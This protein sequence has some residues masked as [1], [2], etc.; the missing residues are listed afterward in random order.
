MIIPIHLPKEQKEQII[1]KVQAY[2]EEER[3]ETIGDLAAEQ[4]IDFM[5]KE[6]GPYLYNKA[7]ADARQMLFEKMSVMEEDLY[8]LEKP[9]R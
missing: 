2:F 6:L 5:I 9:I 8:S 3:S 7:I 4:M 1:L